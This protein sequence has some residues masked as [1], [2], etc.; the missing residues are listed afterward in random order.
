[1][2]FVGEITIE[3]IA[4]QLL[5]LLAIHF[6]LNLNTHRAFLVKL[7]AAHSNARYLIVLEPSWGDCFTGLFD[8]RVRPD[9]TFCR[10]YR[11]F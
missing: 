6:F 1:M 10:S 11:G 9:C 8:C 3:K 4:E 5:A 2:V 7:A